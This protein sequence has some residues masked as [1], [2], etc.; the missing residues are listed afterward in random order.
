VVVALAARLAAL[1]SC[2]THVSLRLQEGVNFTRRA[3][4]K[5]PAANLADTQTKVTSKASGLGRHRAYG[6]CVQGEEISKYLNPFTASE[7]IEQ[8]VQVLLG[9]LHWLILSGFVLHVIHMYIKRW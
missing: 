1:T 2:G 3:G 4:R 9:L 6:S 8:M 5:Q 7:M